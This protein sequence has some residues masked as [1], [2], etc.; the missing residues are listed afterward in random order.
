MKKLLPQAHIK[1]QWA[2]E[3]KNV[4]YCNDP[5]KPGFIEN[6]VCRYEPSQQGHRT[7]LESACDMIKE[8][9]ALREIAEA[10]PTAIVK[11]S[12]GLTVLRSIIQPTRSEMTWGIWLWGPTEIGKSHHAHA[13]GLQRG[14][15]HSKIL[16]TSQYWDGYDFEPVVVFEDFRAG[17]KFSLQALLRLLDK[18]PYLVEIKGAHVSIAP[19]FVVF[20]TPDPPELT[21]TETSGAINQLQ[22]RLLV[23]CQPPVGAHETWLAEKVDEAIANKR[24]H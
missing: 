11:F 9:K 15:M 4:K 7:D 22:R 24:L 19:K 3:E 17:E 23:C 10:H 21:F 20:T 8:G 1:Y 6:L 5:E 16:T 18:Y 13:F 12:R 2:S 14:P